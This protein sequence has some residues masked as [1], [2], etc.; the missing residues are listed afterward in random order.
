METTSRKTTSRMSLL[1]IAKLHAAISD[2]PDDIQLDPA[3]AAEALQVMGV[4][5]GTQMLA[6]IRCKSSK[7]P[8]FKKVGNGRIV[9]RLGDLRRFAGMDAS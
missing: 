1:E 8:A 6:T 9:Y 4:N 7:G 2:M 3:K 5:I